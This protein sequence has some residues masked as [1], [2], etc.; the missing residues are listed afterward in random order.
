M[1][2][3]AISHYVS[4]T[5]IQ[6]VGYPTSVS[7]RNQ[8]D[9]FGNLL[10]LARAQGERNWEYRRRLLDAA[11]WQ[12]NCSYRGL[13]HG[14][15]R[16]LGLAVYTA[17][18]ISPKTGSNGAFLARDPYI[19][20][21]G[22]HLYLYNDYAND[23]LEYKIDRF[24]PGGNYEHIGALVDFI[25]TSTYFHAALW[26]GVDRWRRSMEILNQSN[27]VTITGERV[28]NSSRFA[29]QHRFVVDG[30][31]YF[32]D[33]VTF[34][35]EVITSEEVTEKGEY[36]VEYPTGIVTV[37]NIP[38]GPDTVRYQY[39]DHLFRVRASPVILYDIAS[40]DFQVKM[41]EQIL[42]DDGT[43]ANGMPTALGV[44]IINELLSVVPMYW[45]T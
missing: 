1:A 26:P 34:K 30:S 43:Y 13:V 12:A 27:R 15:T 5:S 37:Y 9:E 16:E 42:Q 39:T 35:T 21:E 2:S 18:T 33:R 32:S 24:E 31:V 44:D 20:F 19:K 23:G 40:P 14:I 41:F 38:T 4:V 36:H 17:M 29:L 7:R 11:Y 10:G 45:G 28:P 3:H 22:A 6:S 25:N 8:F